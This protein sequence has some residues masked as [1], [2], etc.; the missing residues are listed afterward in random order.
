MNPRLL[1]LPLAALCFGAPTSAQTTE[2]VSVD[3]NG[4]QG[5]GY[6]YAYRMTPD[7]L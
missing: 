2:R 5:N 6:S 3:A 1:F 7:A 4:V